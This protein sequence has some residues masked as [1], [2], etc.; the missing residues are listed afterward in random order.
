[1]E[2]KILNLENGKSFIKYFASPYL[3]EQFKR[4]IKYS[5][6][7]KLVGEFNGRI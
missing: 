6:K 1:M 4:K 3:A 2:L 5:K 7:L